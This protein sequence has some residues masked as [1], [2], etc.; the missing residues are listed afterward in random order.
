MYLAVCLCG[1]DLCICIFIFAA[2]VF[3]LWCL[4]CPDAFDFS[5]NGEGF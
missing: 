4:V 5:V 1:A 2:F 3:R